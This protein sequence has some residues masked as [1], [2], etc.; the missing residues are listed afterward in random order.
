MDLFATKEDVEKIMPV[1][2][3]YLKEDFEKIYI[4]EAQELDLKPLLG[5]AFYLDLLKNKLKFI[6]NNETTEL[7]K[8]IIVVLSYFAYA[9]FLY[10]SNVVASSHGI[11]IKKTDYS[12]PLSLEERKNFYYRYRKDA[13][14]YFDE[15]K[16]FLNKN[17]EEFPNWNLSDKKKIVNNYRF[18]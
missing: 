11:V 2:D 16:A 18:I 7:Y 12:E 1:P 14:T 5:E 4:R 8:K 3:G 17:A 10:K 13:Y 9:R 15:L 6:N